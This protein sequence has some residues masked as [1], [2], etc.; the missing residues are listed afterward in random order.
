MVLATVPDAPPTT[1]NQRATS[2]PA[3]ISAKEP[4]VDGSRFRVS[5]LRWLSSF[6]LESIVKLQS[7]ELLRGRP[8][9]IEIPL[10]KSSGTMAAGRTDS[11]AALQQRQTLA[12]TLRAAALVSG[13]LL[14][15]SAECP[16][17][18]H[19]T[20][21]LSAARLC[22]CELSGKE[23]PLSV[24]DF[25]I[26]G[27]AS[28]VA[29]VGQPDGLLQVRDGILLADPDLMESLIADQR[30]GY[31]PECVLNRLPVSD[32]RLLVLR[33]GQPQ[34]S[35]KSSPRENGLAHLCAVRPDSNLRAH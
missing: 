25:E 31:I 3:P 23:R 6:S 30:I 11:D 10:R 24:Q 35:A 4:K 27:G 7:A 29:H 18:L 1:R 8:L 2:C 16:V 21:V 14:P 32:Q 22:K 5:A 9:C 19:E 15:A 26:S 12:G 34:I 17:E 33:L 28:L 13:L 20:L